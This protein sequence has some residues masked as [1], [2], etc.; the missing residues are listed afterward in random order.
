MATQLNDIT[1]YVNDEQIAYMSDSLS[2][3][4]GLGEYAIRNAVVGGGQTEQIFSIDLASKV[5]EIKISMP[6]TVASEKLVRKWK[7]LR[8]TNV[9]E[10]IGSTGTDYNKIFTQAAIIG[11]PETSFST[12]GN[13]EVEFKSNPAQ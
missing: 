11:D 8:N 6:S 1:V 9:V 13:I 10:L 3:K 5:G 2:K 4:D 12:D 7:L